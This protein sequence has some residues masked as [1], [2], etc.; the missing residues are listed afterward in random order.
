MATWVQVRPLSGR[1]RSLTCYY[2][3]HSRTL[4]KTNINKHLAQHQTGAHL[5]TCD[6]TTVHF[7]MDKRT[8]L[9]VRVEGGGDEAW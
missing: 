1:K 7:N 6:T 8:N 5:S 4:S 3:V 2:A 9:D